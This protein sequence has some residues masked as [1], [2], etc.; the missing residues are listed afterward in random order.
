[1]ACST[2]Q[3]IVPSPMI[4]FLPRRGM[5]EAIRLARSHSPKAAES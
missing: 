2:T 4:F 1:M 3:R 5:T